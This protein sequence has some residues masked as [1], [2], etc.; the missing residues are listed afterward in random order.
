MDANVARARTREGEPGGRRP[1]SLTIRLVASAVSVLIAVVI[2]EGVVRAFFPQSDFFTRSDDTLGVMGVANAKGR[3]REPEF[4]TRVEMNSLGFRDHERPLEKAKDGKR[5]LVLGDSFT[6]ALQVEFE[7]TFHAQ[8]EEHLRAKLGPSFDLVSMGLPGVGTAQ[9]MTLYERL[10]S[11]FSPDVVLVMWFWNDL[12]DNNP[13]VKTNPSFR[14]GPGPDELVPV[15]WQK[16]V[17]SE[18]LLNTFVRSNRIQLV[19]LLARAY[20]RLWLRA[21][22]RIAGAPSATPSATPE[23]SPS[24]PSSSPPVPTSAPTLPTSAPPLD[25]QSE[26]WEI[27]RRILKRFRD[28][29]NERG[30]KLVVA[31]IPCREELDQHPTGE[32]LAALCRGLGIPSVDLAPALRAARAAHPDALLYFPVDSHFTRNGHA[33]I[34]PPLL[35]ALEPLLR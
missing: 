22:E 14:L 19:S 12:Q 9:E 30:A 21:Q 35:E 34:V 8:L 3:M 2:A 16:A 25:R 11:R 27:T 32:H 23:A 10:G 26:S 28:E 5:I 6:E 18:G 13:A 7:E 17:G 15:P 31:M 20:R 29:T 33:A 24:A 4:S 1:R